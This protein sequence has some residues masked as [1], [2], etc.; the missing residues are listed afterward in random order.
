MHDDCLLVFFLLGGVTIGCKRDVGAM[1]KQ[2][3]VDADGCHCC[4]WMSDAKRRMQLVWSFT[5]C[6][7]AIG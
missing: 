2:R 1:K 7:F 4:Q 3:C 6:G 5:E